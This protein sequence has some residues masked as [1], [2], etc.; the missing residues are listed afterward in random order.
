[1]LYLCDKYVIITLLGVCVC[2]GLQ[3]YVVSNLD[4]NPYMYKFTHTRMIDLVIG[5]LLMFSFFLC[6]IKPEI[7]T[8][9]V[10]SVV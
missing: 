2:I 6:Y 7:L 10:N 3:P 5:G 1:M 4:I 9:S 8:I